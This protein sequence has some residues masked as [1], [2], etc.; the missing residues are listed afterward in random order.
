MSTPSIDIDSCPSLR[1][2]VRLHYDS[3]RQRWVLLAPERILELDSIG[4]SIVQK[5]D[6]QRSVHAITTAFAK[7][8]DAPLTAI[9][10]DVLKFVH[11][12]S[13]KHLLRT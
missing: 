10:S 2:G 11:E 9:T 13:E 5:L 8:Y 6:G 1:N 4:A 12:L 7:E 3:S